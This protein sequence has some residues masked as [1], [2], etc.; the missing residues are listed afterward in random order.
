MK[1]F[2]LKAFL[3][4]LFH[5]FVNCLSQ[6]ETLQVGL[7][8]FSFIF[9]LASLY[10]YFDVCQGNEKFRLLSLT[11]FRICMFILCLRLQYVTKRP[12]SGPTDH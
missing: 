7:N 3:H 5:S 9:Y 2:M 6:R 11:V 12:E 4:T 10:T 1:Y 8:F